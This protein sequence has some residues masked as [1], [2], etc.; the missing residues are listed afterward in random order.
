MHNKNAPSTLGKTQSVF[1]SKKWKL[2]LHSLSHKSINIVQWHKLSFKVDLYGNI[3]TNI[4]LEFEI[5]K[6]TTEEL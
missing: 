2:V 1:F 3:I 4:K 5:K 6:I